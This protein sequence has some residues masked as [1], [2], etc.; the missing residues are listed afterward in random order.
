MHHAVDLRRV[1][2]RAP[3]TGRIDEDTLDAPELSRETSRADACLRA[4]Q[5]RAAFLRDRL[6]HRV[7]VGVCRRPVD[8]RVGET[9]DPL[10]LCRLEKLEQL[11]EFPFGLSGKSYNFV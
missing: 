11:L 10:E 9:A 7:R 3:D 5:T 6:R 2:R 8:W 1:G 4:H